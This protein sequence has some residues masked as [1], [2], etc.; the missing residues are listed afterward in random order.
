MS[1]SARGYQETTKGGP[2]VIF[3]QREKGHMYKKNNLE[4]TRSKTLG[5]R[6]HL[7]L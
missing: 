7:S 2:H 3:T 6:T 1:I 5:D 4:D